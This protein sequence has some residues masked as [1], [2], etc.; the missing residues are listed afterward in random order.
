MQAARARAEGD[1]RAFRAFRRGG[2][3]VPQ[4]RATVNAFL[5]VEIRHAIFT[6]RDGRAGTDLNAQ[7][8]AAALALVRKSKRD[9]IGLAGLRLHLATEQECVLVRDE[10][11][12]C[13]CSSVLP[14]NLIFA[15]LKTLVSASA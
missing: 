13:N 10:P 4:A 2:G 6:G 14:G 12:G 5:A 1:N 9:V 3:T 15:L 11:R 7:L 8:R